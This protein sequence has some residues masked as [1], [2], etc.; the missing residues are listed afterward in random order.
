VCLNLKETDLGIHY[1][2]FNDQRK[3]KTVVFTNGCFDI[4]HPGHI[5]YL[6]EAKSLGD[7]L[8]V[9]L[10]S[11]ESVRRLKGANRPVNNQDD[12][13]F[14]LENLKAIDF[15]FIFDEDTPYELVSMIRP[16][17]LVKG[18]D[19]REDQIIGHD[20]VRSYGGKVLS[21]SFKD[22]YSTTDFIKQVQGKS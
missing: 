1:P 6:N 5:S 20:V 13:Q 12:R 14:M 15:V 4:L 9:G 21:L 17:I 18:G 22:G 16:D 3:N 2:K 7:L 8:I 10:N 19:W 11:D